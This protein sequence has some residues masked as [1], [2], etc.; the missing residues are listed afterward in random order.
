MTRG[1][2]MALS[3]IFR[4]KQNLIMTAIIALSISICVS[5]P[6]PNPPFFP[7][8]LFKKPNKDM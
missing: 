6:P 3:S 8:Y 4:E 5:P 7:I 1:A 2:V